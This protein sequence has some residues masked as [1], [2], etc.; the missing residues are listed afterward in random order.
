MKSDGLSETAFGFIFA[1]ARNA[2]VAFG[3]ARAGAFGSVRPTRSAK[4][5]EGATMLVVGLG[6]A[7]TESRPPCA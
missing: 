6:G 2:E 1:L 5:L 4:S 7:G 3:N